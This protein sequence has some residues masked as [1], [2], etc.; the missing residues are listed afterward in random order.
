MRTK[1]RSYAL[2]ATLKRDASFRNG[3]SHRKWASTRPLALMSITPL[4]KPS[5]GS[6]TSQPIDSNV[7]A[8]T[9]A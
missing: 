2:N 7:D 5:S 6:R 8:N 9:S 1:P 4:L 3:S